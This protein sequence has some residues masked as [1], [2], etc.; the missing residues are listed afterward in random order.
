MHIEATVAHVERH[1]QKIAPELLGPAVEL[2]RSAWLQDA[3]P[4]AVTPDA[5]SDSTHRE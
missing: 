1:L 5:S 2:P 3:L 4:F